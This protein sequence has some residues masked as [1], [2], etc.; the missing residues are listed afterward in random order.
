[1]VW[2]SNMLTMESENLR[3]EVYA[4]IYYVGDKV[5][6]VTPSTKANHIPL[7]CGCSYFLLY[8]S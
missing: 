1:M 8:W 6:G 2:L 7:A 4:S 5:I 3:M